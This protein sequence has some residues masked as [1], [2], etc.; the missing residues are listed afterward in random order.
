MICKV[1]SLPGVS[2][3]RLLQELIALMHTGR[4]TTM[5]M[6]KCFKLSLAAAALL[7]AAQAATASPLLVGSLGAGNWTSGDTRN[8][9]G[10]AANAA[11][12]DAQ[13]KFLGEG[14]VAADAA[15]NMPD[16]SP[17]N[18]L[19]NKGYLRL[20]GTNSNSG[21]SDIGYLDLGGIA[22]ASAL[23]SN[24]FSLS[25]RHLRDA[26]PTPRTVGQSISV[27]DGAAYYTFSY[28]ES[29]AGA[30]WLTSSISASTG[31]YYLYG[32][33]AFGASGPRLTL[34][35]WAGNS[36]WGFLFGSSFDVVRLGFN[37]GSSSRNG[38]VYVDWLQTSLLNGG[39][40]VDFVSPAAATV[41]EPQTL[42]LVAVALLGLGAARRRRG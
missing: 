20:D 3:A 10:G 41:P 30:D 40:V 34:S 32:A 12:I 19:G 24:D 23:V 14:V 26:N 9:S 33:G 29:V 5:A 16:A 35:E 22:S 27:S 4:R 38:L 1:K 6:L 7:V 36:S 39:D 11:Q 18:S 37:I 17:L 21:K 25:F 31:G 2:V 28:V 15:G 42:M 8:A 13:I